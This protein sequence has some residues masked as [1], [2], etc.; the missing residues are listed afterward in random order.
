MRLVC[1]SVNLSANMI[2]VH[3]ITMLLWG[4]NVRRYSYVTYSPA[5][6]ADSALSHKLLI[7][8]TNFTRL[9]SQ[10]FILQNIVFLNVPCVSCPTATVTVIARRVLTA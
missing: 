6:L 3:R 2:Q 7:D 5:S 9:P 4:M 8:V 1:Q 10:S